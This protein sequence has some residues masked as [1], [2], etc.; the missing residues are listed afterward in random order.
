MK[1]NKWIKYVFSATVFFLLSS[2]GGAAL[3]DTEV[4]SGNIVRV[5]NKYPN[6]IMVTSHRLKLPSEYIIITPTSTIKDIDGR[7]IK[8][9]DLKLPC[10]AEVRYYL[11]DKMRDA[12]LIQMRILEYGEQ[13]SDRFISKEPFLRL[14]E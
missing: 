8:L 3:L 10:A 12:E 14:P 13:T 11:R 7:I 6:C 4:F 1:M 5:T 9:K 2:G